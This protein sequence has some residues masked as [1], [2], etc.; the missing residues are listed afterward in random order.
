MRSLLLAIVAVVMLTPAAASSRTITIENSPGGLISEHVER[1]ARM[2]ARGD[3]VRITGYCA[4]AC[5]IVLAKVPRHRICVGPAAVLGFHSAS[6][7]DD[8][9]RRVHS[10]SGTEWLMRL[11]PRDIK[12]WIARNGGLTPEMR[13]LRGRELRKHV[14]ACRT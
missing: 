4:S 10:R 9:G 12:G 2:A 14:R 13:Y 11:Y 8:A 1:Y 6:E 5:T 7:V 3:R